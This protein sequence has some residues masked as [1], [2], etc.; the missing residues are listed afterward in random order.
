MR[1]HRVVLVAALA[2]SLAAGVFLACNGTNGS[3][4]AGDACHSS[5]ECAP[6]L[7]CDFNQ[8][9]AICAGNLTPIPDGA[10]PPPDA[11]PGTP[12]APPGPPDAAPPPDAP[13]GTPDA[14]AL[15]DAPPPPPD[16][17]PVPDAPPPPPDAAPLPDA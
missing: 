17:A 12:D 16:A 7:V 10:P 13:P 9:P 4:S 15:P 5:T 6:G 11:P 8:S 14:A 3:L 1:R 2:S